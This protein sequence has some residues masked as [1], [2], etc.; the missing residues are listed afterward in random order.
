[1]TDINNLRTRY[2]AIYGS[3]PCNDFAIFEIE[4][5]LGIRLPEDFKEISTFY[6]GGLLGGIS[7]HEIANISEA[8][9]IVQETLRLRHSIGL[10]DCYVVIA[11]PSESLIVLNTDEQPAVIWCDAVEAKNINSLSFNNQPDTWR[12]YKEFFSYLLDE[13]EDE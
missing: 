11:E 3:E 7:H 1:M 10:L 2:E 12:S 9:N 6:S 5:K 8:T 4:E 13:E